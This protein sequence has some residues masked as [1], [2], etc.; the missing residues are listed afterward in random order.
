MEILDAAK[1]S[2]NTVAELLKKI[3]PTSENVT[4][5]IEKANG[6]SK[7]KSEETRVN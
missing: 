2:Q 1:I 6:K 3:S 7:K 5:V 4:K